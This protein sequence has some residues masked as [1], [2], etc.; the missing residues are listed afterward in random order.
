MTQRHK[1]FLSYH[2][3]LDVAAKNSFVASFGHAFVDHSVRPGDISEDVATET[4]L[5]KIREDYL[6]DATVT[7]V[8]I[9]ERTWT[10]RFVD[11]EIGASIR[12]TKNNSRMGLLG[13]LLPSYPRPSPGKYD[14]CTIPARLSDNV[15]CGYAEVYSYPSTADELKTWVHRAFTARNGSILPDNSR[16]YRRRSTDKPAHGW[17]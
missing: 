13:V 11:W 14:K 1:V 9:G 2:H 10:R 16:E 4:V 12:H 3:G 15:D 8:L 7:V 17:C 5:R 6:A